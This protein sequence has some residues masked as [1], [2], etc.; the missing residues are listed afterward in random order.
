MDSRVFSKVTELTDCADDLQSKD[1]PSLIK[2]LQSPDS[3]ARLKAHDILSCIGAAAIPEL[4][5]A[6]STADVHLR[7]Q[8]IKVFDSIQD[9][10]TIPILIR[11]LKHENA[12]IRWAAANALINHRREI[13]LPL[14]EALTH[15]FDSLWFRQSAHHIFHVLHDNGKL[16]P[17]EE[18]VYKALED[19]TPQVSVPWAAEKA[20]E[21]LQNEQNN[22]LH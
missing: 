14:L 11:Q 10:M 20:L 5:K 1:I 6:L 12:E 7:W 9:P 13:I 3:I 22:L 21:A 2:R 8:I 16:L 18:K 4:L 17:L 19:I 15:N